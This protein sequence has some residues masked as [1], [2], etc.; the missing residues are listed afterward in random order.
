[1]SNVTKPIALDESIN[2]TENTPRNIADVLA[3]ELSNI[4]DKI[5]G[6]GSGGSGGHIIQNA[7]GANLTQRNTMQFAD[8]HV[9]DDS[10]NEKTVIENIKSVA[11]ADYS[12]ETEDGLYLIPDGEGSVI[13][14]ASEDFVKVVSDGMKTW[15]QL[16]NELYTLLDLSKLKSNSVIVGEGYFLVLVRSGTRKYFSSAY[17]PNTSSSQTVTMALGDN[18]SYYRAYNSSDGTMS[19]VTSSVPSS[20]T[21]ITLYYGNKKATVDLQTTANRCVT[22]DDKTVQQVFDAMEFTA[23]TGIT[24]GTGISDASMM[25]ASIGG[26][27]LLRGS[28]KVT[29]ARASGDTIMSGLGILGGGVGVTASPYSSG[30]M[31]TYLNGALLSNS[32]L[33]VSANAYYF[34]GII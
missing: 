12:S 2:T 25:K 33:A 17:V 27:T 22:S 19:D 32:T 18:N 7:S 6:G 1:M 16:L 14:P 15:G 5:Q 13:E 24:P 29:S 3:D 10:T 20:G 28:F 34:F 26:R 8:S 31:A 11:S 4:A 21:K 9:S 30:G 23:I